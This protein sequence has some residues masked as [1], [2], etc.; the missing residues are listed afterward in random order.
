MASQE[1]VVEM[2][3]LKLGATYSVPNQGRSI[4]P[5]C[6]DITVVWLE[7]DAIHYRKAGDPTVHQTSRKRF[8]E[9]LAGADR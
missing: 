2:D 7:T 6:V 8:N 9:I 5:Q 1:G 3:D 4:T